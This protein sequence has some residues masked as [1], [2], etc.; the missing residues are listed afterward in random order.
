M[1]GTVVERHS[2]FKGKTVSEEQN[3]FLVEQ[4]IKLTQLKT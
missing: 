2:C 1:S 3:K 4:V